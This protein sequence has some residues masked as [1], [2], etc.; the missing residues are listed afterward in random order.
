MLEKVNIISEDKFIRYTF[1]RSYKDIPQS[2]WNTINTV[3][4]LY[5]TLTYLS[6]IEDALKKTIDFWYIL[7]YDHKRPVGIAYTQLIKINPSQLKNQ[8]LPCKL[9]DSLKNFFIKNIE[10]KTLVCGNLFACGENGF[11]F[12]SSITNDEALKYLDLA[13]KDIRKVA[14]P[15][16]KPSFILLKEFWQHN[17]NETSRN[18]KKLDYRDFEVDVNMVLSIKPNWKSFEDYLADLRT[19]FRT[20]V[21]KTFEKSSAVVIKDLSYQEIKTY[22]KTIDELYL[23]VIENADFKFGNL[24]ADTFI[25]LK[26]KLKDRFIFKAFFLNE[27]IVGFSTAF[28]FNNT[29]EANHIGLNYQLNKTHHLYQRMLYDYVEMA[30]RY[31][32]DELILGRTAETIKSSLGAEPVPMKLFVKHGNSI[33]NALLKPLVDFITPNDYELRNPFKVQVS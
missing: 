4:N 3:G 14:H 25:G 30:I 9:S 7:F 5:L 6:V 17:N 24:N 27:I 11:I 12:E 2:D 1:Y 33:S 29:L 16:D 32:V 26:E 23:S 19:K 21:K 10:V 13:L 8:N 22:S 18:L 31:Q 20:R 28:L 15:E